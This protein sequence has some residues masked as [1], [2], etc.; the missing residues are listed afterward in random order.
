MKLRRLCFLRFL[1]PSAKGAS[2]P[3]SLVSLST[4]RVVVTR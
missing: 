1:L 3:C 4:I 2:L